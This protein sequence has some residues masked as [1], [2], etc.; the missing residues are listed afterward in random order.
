MVAATAAE[1][2]RQMNERNLDIE[3][4]AGKL[5]VFLGIGE[6]FFTEVAKLRAI[7]LIWAQ[8]VRAFGGGKL[9]Q[10][11]R[12]HA[13]ARQPQQDP[14]RSTPQYAARHIGSIGRGHRWS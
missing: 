4:V 14:P 12:L 9:A 1:Y 10:R 11:I 13:R 3:L 8:V 2:L 7:K 6:N 5:Q